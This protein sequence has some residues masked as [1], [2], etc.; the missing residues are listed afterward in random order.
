VDALELKGLHHLTAVTGDP[1]LN[2]AFYTQVLG[3]RLVKKTVNQDDTGAYHLFYGDRL[4][5]PGTELTFFDWPLAGRER[6]GTGVV[7]AVC[8]RVPGPAALAAWAERLAEAGVRH[9]GV[10]ELGGRGTL[11]LADPEGQRLR[12][13]DA[14]PS[15]GG[16]SWP[17]GPV[18]EEL[19]IRGLHAVQLTL[20]QAG[21][22]AELLTGV[23]GFRETEPYPGPEGRAVRRFEAGPGG[24]G[25]EV[26]LEERTD[27]GPG[28]VGIGGVHHLAFRTPDAAQQEAWRRRL[29]EA[30]VGVTPVIDRFYFRSIYFREPGGVLFEIATD[31]PGFSTDEEAERLG[32]KLALP[33]FLEPYRRR[34][35]AGLKPIR[36]VELKLA[37]RVRTR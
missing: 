37:S 7:T 10:R 12:L 1:S 21:P 8:L 30:G 31:G 29:A 36:P 18:P 2:V 5:R 9:Q 32:E 14:G 33:P 28:R 11:E 6:R 35:E 3:L 17:G 24:P 20:G 34:I 4:G 16:G 25:T 19:A 13:V 22:T 23:L 26:H 27:L 15:P